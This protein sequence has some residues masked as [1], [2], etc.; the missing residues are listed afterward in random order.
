MSAVVFAAALGEQSRMKT[1]TKKKEKDQKTGEV[2]TFLFLVFFCS[3]CSDTLLA[4]RIYAN[5]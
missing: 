4:N 2:R 1:D 5:G 3:F